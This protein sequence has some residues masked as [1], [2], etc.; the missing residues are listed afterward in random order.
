[1]SSPTAT[2]KR[3][4]RRTTPKTTPKRSPLQERS[5]SQKNEVAARLQRDSKQEL[6]DAEIFTT[7]PFPTKPQHI[8]LPSTIRKQRSRHNAE[9]ELPGFF[10][11]RSVAE[12]AASSAT[13]VSTSS[14]IARNAHRAPNLQLKKS[15]T[16]LRD[17]Y[18][19]QAEHS[20]PS[21]AVTSPVLRPTTAS[22][23]L[24]SASS[25]EGLAGR[26]AWELLG[27]PKVSADDLATLP[28]LSEDVVER[29]NSEASFAARV[30]NKENTSS[31]NFR[32][33]G[34]SSPQ[35][36]I[37]EDVASSSDP[38]EGSSSSG[39]QMAG[40]SSPN[41]I[42]LHHSSSMMA[43]DPTPT[44]LGPEEEEAESSPNVVKLGTTSPARSSSSTLSQISNGSRKRKRAEMEGSAYAGRTPL[45]MQTR[46]QR[47]LS[48]P[49]VQNVP[50]SSDASLQS[51]EVRALPSS[52]PEMGSPRSQSQ[53]TTSPIIR[54]H[55]GRFSAD[56]SSIVSAHTNLQSVLGSSPEP[57]VHRP[58][59]RAPDVNQFEILSMQ[60][61]QLSGPSNIPTGVGAKLSPVPS[62]TDIAV[63]ELSST[64]L[65]S[66]RPPQRTASRTSIFTEEL[67]DIL[68]TES[69]APAQAYMLHHDL[70]SSQVQ[71][72]SDADR[73]EA[74]DELA[75]LPRQHSS[76]AA[77]LSQ[78][79][80]SFYGSS[81][82]SNSLSRMESLRTSMDTRL[83][84]M[85]SFTHGRHDSF[86]SSVRP[87]SSG[88]HMSVNAVPTWAQRYYSGFYRNSFHYLYQ[89]S[90]NL[91]YQVTQVVPPQRHSLPP[92][93]RT[94]ESTS[95][96]SSIGPSPRRSLSK[97]IRSS[98]RNFIPSVIL[99]ATRPRL[100]VRKSHLTAGIGPLVSNPVR[101]QS[102]ILSRPASSYQS[103]KA[104]RHVSLPLSAAD[105]RYHW[106]G[107]IDTPEMSEVDSRTHSQEYPRNLP[108]TESTYM[109]RP[110]R[111]HRSPFP[112]MPLTTPRL[113]RDRRLNT[114]STDSAGF[115][116]PY[117]ARSRW[118]PSHGYTDE[119]GRPTW[120]KVDL[121]DLQVL[122]FISGFLL[123]FTWFIGAF[124][125]LPKR[126]AKYHDIEKAE[127][128]AQQINFS[129][130][131]SMSEWD[132]MDVVARLR[133]ERHLRGLEEV[134]WQNARWWRR[135]N[136]WMC[137]VGL[138][139]LVVV[140][141]LAVIGTK[142]HW[143]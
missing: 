141:T 126:P 56:S 86:R 57:P 125:P 34:S 122:C 92:S 84:S 74:V 138:V 38:M 116:A 109:Q 76:F 80:G 139:V 64:D 7:T 118:Q 110:P 95:A 98:I 121:K 131:P 71:M 102:L 24:R 50:A 28:T 83:Q 137:L 99:P 42:Q 100:D 41:I 101:P 21:S 114:G 133:L 25:S 23:R 19:A 127:L 35:F 30:R 65:T 113:H 63:E 129:D 124:S 53:P 46:R 6:T 5:S 44:S 26:S 33:F 31:P 43:T 75:A 78:A 87:G 90:N 105:P 93:A 15:V 54:V 39:L 70:N 1:M 143:T 40:T 20:R 89:S 103:R 29:I 37:Y 142:G 3:S 49:T 18:E 68:D 120:F 9:N 48:S 59:V 132:Q 12:G 32:T 136:R 106:N 112:M 108:R 22:S 10:F 16:A 111:Q 96:R 115:G 107:V 8:L 97:S 73:H 69:I 61:R 2:P 47:A 62:L 135:M 123:P 81:S 17:M 60:K 82:G 66:I 91:S 85:R 104:L 134:K 88:S 128:E 36:P 27:L 55:G 140:I 79:R 67:D 58:V 130:R 119:I 13:N 11:N 14:Q 117:N 51:S 94:Y 52:P 4:S 45:F 77:A 72:I